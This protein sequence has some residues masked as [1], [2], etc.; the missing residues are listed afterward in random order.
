L[1]N[2]DFWCL[3]KNSIGFISIILIIYALLLIPPSH[4]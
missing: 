4:P 2:T 1:K 3:F